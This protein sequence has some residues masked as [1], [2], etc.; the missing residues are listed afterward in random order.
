MKTYIENL[1]GKKMKD[2][3]IKMLGV[4]PRYHA[5]PKLFI[6]EGQPC[7]NLEPEAPTEM[8]LA[9]FEA[10]FFCVCTV[11]RGAGQGMPY[12]F[13]RQDVFNVEYHPDQN[14]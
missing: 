1:L 10:D 9:I 12:L 11:E 4:N 8:V 2:K 5:S 3:H 14:P 13:H 6:E 7:A